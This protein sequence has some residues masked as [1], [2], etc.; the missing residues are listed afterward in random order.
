MVWSGVRATAE[1][2]PVTSFESRADP[3][4]ILIL[5]LFAVWG[6]TA[7]LTR[8]SLL[9]PLRDRLDPNTKL[10]QLARCAMCTGLWVGIAASLTGFGPAHLLHQDALALPLRLAVD[11]AA[12]SA[13][14]DLMCNAVDALKGV[15]SLMV[16][17]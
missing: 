16:K 6:V 11:G 8:S 15:A 17:Q 1:T 14:A 2:T 9:A 7:I 12:A 13:G 4:M 5:W 10:G 3:K